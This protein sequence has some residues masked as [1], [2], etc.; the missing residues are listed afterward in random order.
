MRLLSQR[1]F[2]NALGRS[3]SLAGGKGGGDGLPPFLAAENLNAFIDDDL[4]VATTPILYRKRMV[5]PFSQG[6][7]ITGEPTGEEL[8]NVLLWEVER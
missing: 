5:V 7:G 6:Y 1:A 4:R 2:L 3:R 8:Y